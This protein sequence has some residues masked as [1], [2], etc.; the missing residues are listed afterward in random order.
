MHRRQ[1]RR[2]QLR[3]QRRRERRRLRW[4]GR[5]G[6]SSRSRVL[7]RAELSHRGDSKN[8]NQEGSDPRDDV[9]EQQCGKLQWLHFS[10]RQHL[11]DRII[12][13]LGIADGTENID[14]CRHHHPN[15]EV[16]QRGPRGLFHR[17]RQSGTRLPNQREHAKA[18]QREQKKNVREDEAKI[19]RVNQ[20]EIQRTLEQQQAKQ[21]RV[22]AAL[23][24]VRGRLARRGHRFPRRARTC[25]A[26]TRHARTRP[27]GLGGRERLPLGGE[28]FRREFS[29][30]LVDERSQSREDFARVP[31]SPERRQFFALHRGL[32]EA[33]G[34]RPLE[35][36]DQQQ[37]AE[38]PDREA[39]EIAFRLAVE[40]QQEE[41]EDSREKPEDKAQGGPAR[42]APD[43]QRLNVAKIKPLQVLMNAGVIHQQQMVLA[44]PQPRAAHGEGD[45]E[46]ALAT[47]AASGKRKVF[48]T[49]RLNPGNV[50]KNTIQPTISA[51]AKIAA[52][53]N[54]HLPGRT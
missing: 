33:L 53:M 29:L 51:T 49:H 17:R 26:R 38:K 4:R 3:R 46:I 32:D 54:R 30:R 41:R 47:G 44:E 43:G 36:I 7:L 13:G 37:Q 34:G 27:A 25:R 16:A 39:V 1:G 22:R 45:H 19:V 52:R 28:L 6:R 42:R 18:D 2:R 14:A 20:H 9:E 12:C 10:E 5:D 40:I 23:I 15:A 24:G 31:Q 48:L 8:P 21:P 35:Q 11:R 50:A